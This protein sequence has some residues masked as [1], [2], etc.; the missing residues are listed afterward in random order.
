M[1]E[2]EEVVD[3]DEEVDDQ[4]WISMKFREDRSTTITYANANIISDHTLKKEMLSCF[5]RLAK[6]RGG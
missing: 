5:G 2:D 1:D 4:P 3:T 6:R